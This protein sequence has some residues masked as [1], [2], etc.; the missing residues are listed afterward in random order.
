MATVSPA[1]SASVSSARVRASSS[2]PELDCVRGGLPDGILAEAE[3]RADRLGI[4]ADQVLIA[5]GAID[6]EKYLRALADWLEA[7]FDPLDDTTRADCVLA[8][9]QMI[10]AASHGMLPVTDGDDI[11][12]VVAPRGST[13]R[14]LSRLHMSHP[15]L[16]RRFRITTPAH[17]N[18]FILRSAGNALVRR[19]RDHLNERHPAMSAGPPNRPGAWIAP[20]L[21][22]VTAAAALAPTAAM[23]G[24]HI[25]LAA[26]F[27]GWLALRL[28]CAAAPPRR[29]SVPHVIDEELPT[30]TIIA[31]LW[32]E[33]SSVD[34]LLRA[35]ARFDYPR[36]KLDVILAVE[37]DDHETRAAIAA[38]TAR[39]PITVLTVPAGEPRT[40][41]RALNAALAFAR[42]RFTVVYDAEDRPDRDQLRR[43]LHAFAQGDERLACVQAQLCIH[44][45]DD[46]WLTRLFTAE[47][48]SHFDIFLHGLARL[49]LP[50]PLGGSS[51]HFRTDVLHAVGAWDAYNVTEDADLG[52]RLARFGYASR[53]IVSTTFEEAPARPRAWIHQRT[54]WFK[55]WMQTWCVHMRQPLQLWRD[56]GPAGFVAFQLV[57]G[58]N[59]LSALVHPWFIVGFGLA[60][61]GYVSPAWPMFDFAC[62]IAGYC[63]SAW[64]CLR[65]LAAR[66]LVSTVPWLCL[67]PLHWMLLSLAAWRAFW[68]FVR[69]PYVWEK[70]EHGL[71]RS[72]RL[73]QDSTRALIALEWELRSMQVERRVPAV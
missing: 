66:G 30:Y 6:Q 18:Q 22:L 27:L 32:R 69:A 71:A 13:A 1:R 51:N 20:T 67:I 36:E 46:G 39:L 72:S 11:A 54:R 64:L 25:A 73:H 38:S 56:M 40:K 12:V 21:T 52:I 53:M 44:N 34:E 26:I 57:V 68:Q 50:L 42:G 35:F 65:G 33:A 4:G 31:A 15:A 10:Q 9:D 23:L 61:A 55:G 63:I 70:T 41:P 58:G 17:L 19:A 24:L 28:A 45:T 47:Y 5:S 14:H 29:A 62:L 60:L 8:D 48:A 16:A 59:V 7:T 37:A 2:Y 49:A 43:A 3:A